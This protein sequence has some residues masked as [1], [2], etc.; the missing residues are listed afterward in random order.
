MALLPD[1][2]FDTTAFSI[3]AAETQTVRFAAGSLN[4]AQAE[5]NAG[6]TTYSFTI[7]RTGGTTGATTVTG[8]F[9]ATATDAADFGGSLPGGFRAVIAAGAIST[10]VAVEVSGDTLI[11]GNE[12]FRLNLTGTVNDAG[13][14]TSINGSA[15][16]ATG[17]IQNDDTPTVPFGGIA[18]LE[19]AE[20]LAGSAIVPA[21]SGA[22][23][24]VRLGSIAGSGA[25]AAG[26]AEAIAFDPVTDRAFTTNA[27]LNR[28][29]ITQIGSDGSLTSA[30]LI[31]LTALPDAG[32]VN[33]VAVKNGILAVAYQSQSADQPGTVALF[34]AATGN[35]VKTLSVGVVPDQLTF[36]PDGS[37]LLVANEAETISAANNPAGS[38]SII[39]TSGAAAAATVSNTI[40]FAALNG[41]EAALK[42][43]GF[44]TFPGQSAGA[45]FEPEYISVSPDGTRAY[46]TLQEV[47]GVAVIDLTNPSATQPLAILPLG[48]IDRSLAG[49]AFDASDRDGISLENFDVASLPQPDAIASFE[50]GGFTYFVTANEGDARVGV[51]DEVR[52]SAASYVLDPGAYP[53]AAALKNNNALGRLNVI[54]TAGDTD[55]D[56]DIDQITTF[57]GRGISIFRQNADG[58]I[59]KVRETGGEFEAILAAYRPDIFNVE[60]ASAIDDRSDNK[61]PEPEG[62]TVGQVG[63]RLYAFVTLERTGGVMTYDVTEPSEAT[64]V[65]FTPATAADFA[66]EVVAFVSAADSPTGRALVL[67]ANE[68]SGTLTLY[69]VDAARI[70]TG[71]A[72]TETMLGDASRDRLEGLDGNDRLRGFDGNDVLVGGEGNDVL[73]G[74]SGN[75]NMQGGA[76]NDTF[77]V[78]SIGDLVIERSGE[79]SDTVKTTLT[80][81][82]LGA[83]VEILQF[84]ASGNAVGVGNGLDNTLFGNAGNDTLSGLG[85]ADRLVGGAGNDVLIG[86]A[87]RD[88]LEGGVGDDRFVFSMADFTAS[89]TKPDLIRDFDTFSGDTIDLSAISGLAFVGS[90]AFSGDA[91]EVRSQQIGNSTFVYGDTDADGDAD[92]AI[93]LAGLHALTSNEF[94]L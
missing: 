91:R 9:S 5:G 30:G 22:V 7:E 48:S 51:T 31:D 70:Q 50:V 26:R 27:A 46:V 37:K 53:D 33:S 76:G 85:G 40:S 87:G 56:G 2:P 73:E 81:Y 82:T 60:N 54:S 71:T 63:G 58:T 8:S 6:T 29:D 67:S 66:P 19:A 47:N 59:N 62:V 16:T 24:L 28:I 86:G 25:T 38:V 34:D 32:T 94:L 13:I 45:E 20:S 64:F 77:F 90:A 18:I 65:G 74:G 61:G 79:G 80:S 55:G 84:Q 21:P 41:S 72:A 83:E 89:L 11:E 43:A 12:S 14:A 78:D 15:S 42:A 75:D 4:V 69:S 3:G 17:V 92:F 36:S 88:S 68:V 35:L 1:L 52:L 49:N 93:E 10:M 57:G 39:D 44:N 23:E